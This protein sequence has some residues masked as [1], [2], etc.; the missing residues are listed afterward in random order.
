MGQ[1]DLIFHKEMQ[2]KSRE[3][4]TYIKQQFQRNRDRTKSNCSLKLENSW[5]IRRELLVV[6]IKVKRKTKRKSGVLAET[7]L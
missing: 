7:E 4:P 5:K 1:T 2:S 6:D 3:A